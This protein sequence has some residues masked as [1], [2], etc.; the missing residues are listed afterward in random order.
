[1]EDAG[2]RRARRPLRPALCVFA[3]GLALLLALAG[4]R[5]R[6]A[7][8]LAGMWQAGAALFPRWCDECPAGR[9]ARTADGRPALLVV[10]VPLERFSPALQPGSQAKDALTLLGPPLQ[11]LPDR[12]VFAGP[13]D[14]PGARLVLTLDGE[15]IGTL[16]WHWHHGR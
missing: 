1:M 3:A 15:R 11:R 16:E 14:A 12:Y 6:P 8:T 10:G 7:T 9:R 13:A 2:R 4:C 5:P